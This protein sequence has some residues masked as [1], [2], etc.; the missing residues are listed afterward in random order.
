[1]GPIEVAY[2]LGNRLLNSGWEVAVLTYKGA[3]G[4]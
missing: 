3:Q 1:M 2:G 4:W